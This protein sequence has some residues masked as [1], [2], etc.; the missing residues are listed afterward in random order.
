MG[1]K[2]TSPPLPLLVALAKAIRSR[3]KQYALTIKELAVQ[4]GLSERFLVSVEAGK[5]NIS[6]VKLDAI[7]QALGTSASALLEGAQTTPRLDGGRLVAL[8]GLRGA[9]KTAVGQR[10]AARL[11]IPFVELDVVIAEHA[12][13]PLESIFALHGAEYLRRLEQE[14]LKRTLDEQLD[15]VLATGGGLVTNHAAFNQ[16]KN[17]T[18]TVFL[19]A[20]A[21]DHWNRVVAQGDARPM[22]DREDAMDELRTILRA[23]R[24][25]YE[26]ADFTIDTSALGLERS[27]DAVVRITRERMQQTKR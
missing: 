14:Q 22:A 25:L 27:V 23:R 2:P 21:D 9:G 19:K 11:D 6:V 13:M 3:R 24:A 20:S 10:V 1:P 4:S 12:G 16:L 8:L 15:G 18:T 5:A 7:A 17:S 26:Q